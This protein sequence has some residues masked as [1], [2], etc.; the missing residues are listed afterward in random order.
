MGVFIRLGTECRSFTRKNSSPLPLTESIDAN[1]SLCPTQYASPKNELDW[2]RG[3]RATGVHANTHIPDIDRRINSDNLDVPDAK[4]AKH[5]SFIFKPGPFRAFGNVTIRKSLLTFNQYKTAMF[6]GRDLTLNISLILGILSNIFIILV[7]SMLGK[8]IGKSLKIYIICQAILDISQSVIKIYMNIAAYW[9][10]KYPTWGSYI[11]VI[12]NPYIHKCAYVI[13][14][15]AFF[16]V[17]LVICIQRCIAVFFPL[18]VKNSF[19]TRKPKIIVILSVL[20]HFCLFAINMVR[21]DYIKVYN[22]GLNAT[23]YQ[24]STAKFDKRLGPVFVRI[25][26]FIVS[27]YVPIPIILVS[28]ISIAVVFKIKVLRIRRQRLVAAGTLHQMTNEAMSKKE[29]LTQTIIALALA[30]ILCNSLTVMIAIIMILFR[31]IFV[32]NNL[33][34]FQ[35]LLF[36]STIPHGLYSIFCLI[37]L[38]LGSSAFRL[39]CLKLCAKC[40]RQ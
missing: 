31:N 8:E 38:M 11:Y 5:T 22:S 13:T 29:R 10:E 14:R 12:T 21:Y 2:L 4:N 25:I 23:I 16:W 40:R 32:P 3:E 1:A 33:F 19:L 28:I 35:A 6:W 30:S 34:L 9:R 17:I 20:L 36:L 39:R 26:T 18:K 27:A 37:I 15:G 7:V 24:D